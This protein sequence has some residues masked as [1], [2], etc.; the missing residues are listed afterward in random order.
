M[1]EINDFMDRWFN[2][3]FENHPGSRPYIPKYQKWKEF[4][5]YGLFGTGTFFIAIITYAVLSESLHWNVLLANLVAWVFATL[6]AFFTNRRFV[7]TK[8]RK[9]VFAFLIQFWGFTFGR[10]ITLVIEEWMLYFFIGIMEFPNMLV[11]FFSQ[12]IVIALNY[13]F[14]KLF[15]F[16]K[17][18]RSL[19]KEIDS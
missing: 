16:R 17:N 9:G 18:D 12:I 13:V 1:I 7:F 6:F 8:H 11:K 2:Y 5:M 4:M 3:I 10:L 19:D 15:V 14:S